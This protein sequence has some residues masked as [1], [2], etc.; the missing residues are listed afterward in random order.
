MS[1]TELECN[2]GQLPQ[3]LHSALSVIWGH[4]IIKIPSSWTVPY[5]QK[6]KTSP[7]IFP[8]S[9]HLCCFCCGGGGCILVDLEYTIEVNSCNFES[10]LLTLPKWHSHFHKCWKQTI[11]RIIS[12]KIEM[13]IHLICYLEVEW[14]WNLQKKIKDRVLRS[15]KHL[16]HVSGTHMLLN[17]SW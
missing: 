4:K 10:F 12:L 8:I 15:R 1:A 9:K 13:W 17:V 2:C 5:G 16:S 14:F 6:L 7:S 3:I 11:Q